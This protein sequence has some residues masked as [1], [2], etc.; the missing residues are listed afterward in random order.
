MATHLQTSPI[1]LNNP[2]QILQYPSRA[3][4]TI[5]A[6]ASFCRSGAERRN[7]VCSSPVEASK[8]TAQPRPTRRELRLLLRKLAGS[9]ENA[10]RLLRLGASTSLLTTAVLSSPTP[11]RPASEIIVSPGDEQQQPRSSMESDRGG[12]RSRSPSI[13]DTWSRVAS[14]E[15]LCSPVC[16]L[17]P[18]FPVLR[19]EKLV[20]TGMGMTASIA[21]AEP[22]LFLPAYDHHDPTTKK[23]AI[24]RGYLHLK[25]TKSV[26]IKGISV[27]LRGHAQ[28]I[29]PDGIPPRKV[30]YHDKKDLVTQGLIYLNQGDAVLV[31]NGYGAHR[32]Q[33]TKSG[34]SPQTKEP[35]ATGATSKGG[36]TIS[37]N[38]S[39]TPNEIK[40]HSLPANQSYKSNPP[41]GTGVP[42]QRNYQLFPPG[43]YL[44]NFEFAIDG[45]LPESIKTELGFVRYDLEASVERSGALRPNLLG[46]VEIPV[47]RTPAEG[48]LE[49]VEPIAISRNWE[50]QLHYDIVISGKSFPLGS[51]IPI[52][53]KLTPLAK[54]GCHRI[55]VYVTENIQH[56]TADKTV[57]RLQP[58]KKL[59]LFE[60]RADAQSASTY[61][62]SSMRVISG[63]GVE[64]DHR[65]AAARGEEQVNRNSVSLLGNLD[66]DTGV[67]PTEMEFS[68]QLPSCQAMKGRDESQRLHFDTTYENIQINH[69]IKIV[70]RMSKVD[71]KDPSKRR[72]FEIS[73]D[74]PFHLLSCMATQANLILPAYTISSSGPVVLAEEL[75][76]GCPGAPV[77][78][79]TSRNRSSS[80]RSSSDREDGWN[81]GQDSA[82]PR[83]FTSGSGEL[84]RP[85][86]AHLIHGPN[87]RDARPIHLIRA[88]SFAPPAFEDVPPPPP[89]I[90]PPPDYMSIVGDDDQ[91][92]VLTDYFQRRSYHYE[93][94]DGRGHGRVDIPLTPGGRV[95]RSMD[96]S[97]DWIL[98]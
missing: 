13:A 16:E 75:E 82:T 17:T 44:Y 70:M 29:W 47:I 2:E 81:A 25:T 59:L 23:L 69:W 49:Q 20:A 66:N 28:T 65:E 3:P 72:H 60:K 48:S 87:E 32:Y 89:L 30:Q 1:P 42:T 94:I 51:Q 56:W 61:P 33:L 26:K 39:N 55:K 68:V 36:Y 8:A 67:G 14:Q 78:K 95:S 96:L 80:Q 79:A 15:R 58:P 45:S 21:L 24:L 46:A 27:R 88:P 10:K 54:V 6:L 34:P 4:E 22:A 64:W 35:K 11:S 90:T 92:A 91:E 52:A 38:S 18:S 62:G 7:S 84:T 12:I 43:D 93:G 71:E 40:R 57:H 53:F 98:P 37:V 83:G 63:G 86:Q 5:Q 41:P 97:R 50:D 74:S 73:I 85:E 31:Q 19:N 9:R 77:S 76:C